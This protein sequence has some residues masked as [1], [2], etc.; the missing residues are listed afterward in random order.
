MEFKG[1]YLKGWNIS[2]SKRC[3]LLSPQLKLFAR[4]HLKNLRRTINN[5][6]CQFGVVNGVDQ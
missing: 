5:S 3:R 4:L 2:V 6:L 1:N